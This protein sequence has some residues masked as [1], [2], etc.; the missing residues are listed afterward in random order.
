M[1]C[2]KHRRCWVARPHWRAEIAAIT[3][4]EVTLYV[5][6]VDVDLWGRAGQE[7]AKLYESAQGGSREQ[8]LYLCA[9]ACVVAYI[10]PTDDEVHVLQAQAMQCY[11]DACGWW[12][13]HVHH[14]LLNLC[15]LTWLQ[16]SWN[17]RGFKGMH[18][19]GV[20]SLHAWNTPL[21]ACIHT[22]WK[23]LFATHLYGTF[24]HGL[25]YKALWRGWQGHVGLPP[26]IDMQSMWYLSPLKYTHPQAAHPMQRHAICQLLRLNRQQKSSY[27]VDACKGQAL[28]Q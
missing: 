5:T 9:P 16:A 18:P 11:I 13:A 21:H 19:T 15:H 1:W 4:A 14:S 26:A 27:R 17:Y 20:A 2:A 7:L 23:R 22:V 6:A 12:A 8:G 28:T 3:Q 24:G 10:G 25:R